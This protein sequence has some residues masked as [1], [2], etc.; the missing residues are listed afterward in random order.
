MNAIG[1][2]GCILADRQFWKVADNMSK[3]ALI[4]LVHDFIVRSIGESAS[5]E[6]R[7]EELKSSANVILTHRNDRILK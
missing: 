6:A 2:K 5:S 7:I 3:A 1:K 4:D